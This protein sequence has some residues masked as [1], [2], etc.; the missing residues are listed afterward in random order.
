MVNVASLRPSEIERLQ[1]Q[2][3]SDEDRD[4]ILSSLKTMLAEVRPDG[5][6]DSDR[7]FMAAQMLDMAGVWGQI[8]AE[9]LASTISH[10]PNEAVKAFIEGLPHNYAAEIAFKL[11]TDHSSFK[12]DVDRLGEV[13]ARISQAVEARG[14][15]NV[16]VVLPTEMPRAVHVQMKGR[17]IRGAGKPI[18]EVA[19]EYY[20]AGAPLVVLH[21]EEPSSNEDLIL[22]GILSEN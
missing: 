21:A 13:L 8:Q 2:A 17:P 5:G 20:F 18:S 15:T 4:S 7:I 16:G 14:F 11:V 6:A 19:K 9:D 22:P 1:G 12:R 10:A 3:L